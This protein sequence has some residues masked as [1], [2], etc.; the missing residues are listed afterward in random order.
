MKKYATILNNIGIGLLALL[1]GNG[2]AN[3]TS[4]NQVL[5]AGVYVRTP[6]LSEVLTQGNMANNIPIFMG[7][8]SNSASVNTNSVS[9][10]SNINQIVI[11]YSN[12]WNQAYS[13]AGSLSNT[14]FALPTN[15]WNQAYSYVT[16][17]TFQD[18][19][20]AILTNKFSRDGSLGAL[21]DWNM[22]GWRLKNLGNPTNDADATT[23]F[24]VDSLIAGLAWQ[25][26]VVAFTNNPPVV[27]VLNDRYLVNPIGTNEFAGKDNYIAIV[28]NVSPKGFRFDAAEIGWAIFEQTRNYGYVYNGTNWVPFAG[29]TVYIWNEGLNANGNIIDVNY[30]TGLLTSNKVLKVDVTW[31]DNNYLQTS[32]PTGN[33]NV[34]YNTALWASNNTLGLSNLVYALPTNNWDAAYIIANWASNNTLGLSNLVYALP[35]NNWNT[36]FSWG[37]WAGQGFLT[38]GS[39]ISTL[40]ND[41]GYAFA[42][43]K[44]G[45]SSNADVAAALSVSLS[46]IIFNGANQTNTG[47]SAAFQIDAPTNQ[48][49]LVFESTVKG[50][51]IIS[52]GGGVTNGSVVFDIGLAHSTN[53]PSTISSIVYTGVTLQT[54][55]SNLNDL[56]SIAFT[57]R[58]RVYLSIT[59]GYGAGLQGAIRCIE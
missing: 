49:Y 14:I 18:Q 51:R 44:I 6:T 53:A 2:C 26:H 39:N 12:N 52:I 48:T 43:A 56:G 34:A 25:D 33:W 19:I 55:W 41:A 36:A 37:N 21:A 28:T 17:N 22:D 32:S 30:G 46:N 42:S 35:T 15:N 7:V 1:L 40:V 47:F 59:N 3:P 20:N 23:K 31:L 4:T 16:T 9:Q 10:S 8:N 13:M 50:G 58:Q 24:Y 27:V 45:S 11:D 29:G 5:T 38:A 57:N 54:S